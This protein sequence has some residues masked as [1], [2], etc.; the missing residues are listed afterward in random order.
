MERRE[1]A[2]ASLEK[3]SH[4]LTKKQFHVINLWTQCHT[5]KE[6]AWIRKR[7]EG[8]IC[9]ILKKGIERL[10][11]CMRDELQRVQEKSAYL[12]DY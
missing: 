11:R 9:E 4:K 2:L 10:E 12:P 8:T 6:V 7:S 1:R 3:C 5:S